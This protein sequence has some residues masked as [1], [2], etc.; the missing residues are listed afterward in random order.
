MEH[1]KRYC[2]R[3]GVV[4]YTEISTLNLSLEMSCEVNF[5]WYVVDFIG[6]SITVLKYWNSI[7][8]WTISFYM[9]PISSLSASP[10]FIV[11]VETLLLNQGPKEAKIFVSDGSTVARTDSPVPA[12]GSLEF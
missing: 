10:S 2:K 1:T 7:L 4:L 12:A 5:V 11:Y 6:P 3:V 8:K 9:L